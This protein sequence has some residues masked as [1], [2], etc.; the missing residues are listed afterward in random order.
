MRKTR[1]NAACISKR[2]EMRRQRIIWIKKE[3]RKREAK[4][5]YIKQILKLIRKAFFLSYHSDYN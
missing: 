4:I 3:D 5:N 1:E 2:G